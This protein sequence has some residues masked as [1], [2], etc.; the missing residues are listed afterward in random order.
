MEKFGGLVKKMP[1]CPNCGIRLPEKK[2][3]KFCPNCGVPI[4]RDLLPEKRK[5]IRTNIESR[6]IVFLIV[7]MLCIAAT[8]IGTLTKVDPVEAAEMFQE[9]KGQ[10]EIV[11]S[12]GAQAI[13]SHNL[14]IMLLM[15]VPVIGPFF[16][17]LSLYLTGRFLAAFSTLLGANP[18]LLFLSLFRYPFAVMEY[19]SYALAISESLILVQSM[20]KHD[21]KNEIIVTL[22]MV[23]VCTAI[24]FFAAL[25][26]WFYISIA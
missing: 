8:T 2:D 12:G 9:M 21:F 6:A 1:Y 5:I 7:F 13:F 24:L 14:R 11:K 25:I 16:G 4:P 19:V 15:F 22:I 17:F 18:T 20:V 10:I 23:V 26:E 3:A